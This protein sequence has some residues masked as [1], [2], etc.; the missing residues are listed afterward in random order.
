MYWD[1]YEIW[2]LRQQQHH[3]DDNALKKSFA[4]KNQ[5]KPDQEKKDDENFSPNH[6]PNDLQETLNRTRDKIQQ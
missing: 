3:Y 5:T 4:K 2:S 1:W 6:H